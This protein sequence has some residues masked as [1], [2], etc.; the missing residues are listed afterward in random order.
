ME[1]TETF[2][3]WVPLL[4][5]PTLFIVAF[6]L[7]HFPHLLDAPLCGVKLF[8]GLPCPGCGLTH[9]TVA[10]AHGRLRSSIDY[11]PLGVVI[12]LWLVYQFTRAAFMFIRGRPL[13]PLLSDEARDVV[14][15]VFL[16]ALFVQW[17]VK[18]VM[19]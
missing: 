1:R 4:G 13:R 7:G 17:I 16:G 11:N 18:L 8:I 12:A 3:G 6:V 9:A 19:S 5:V 10:L 14:L 15:Y 2:K